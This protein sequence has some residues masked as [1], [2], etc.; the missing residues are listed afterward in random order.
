MGRMGGKP[1]KD[2]VYQEKRKPKTPIKFNISLDEEQKKAKAKILDSTISIING[3]AGSGKSTLAA[4]IALDLLFNNEK[5]R[6]I[7]TRAMVV[8]GDEEIGFLPGGKDEKLAPFTTP[9]YDCMN[10]LYKKDKIE[11]MIQNGEIEVVPFA[12]MRGRSFS[13]C[14]IIVDEAQNATKL[15]M[16]L[17]LTRIDKGTKVIL[18]GDQRQIDLKNKK[19]SVFAKLKDKF[20]NRKGYNVIDLKVNYRDPIVDDVI[21]LFEEIE[22]EESNKE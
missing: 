19:Q 11:A 2:E 22:A 13:N 20:V 21:E 10:R 18:C 16:E 4:Q 3:K 17:V 1:Y 9:V 14:I 6:I 7:V 5:E 12:W 15:Q 8:S